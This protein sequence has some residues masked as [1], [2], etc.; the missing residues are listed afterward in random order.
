MR[1]VDCALISQGADFMEG[2]LGR[3]GPPSPLIP[4]PKS[5]KEVQACSVGSPV[6][7]SDPDQ[8]VFGR[9]FRI[10]HKH[11]EVPVV[12]ENTGVQ[13]FIFRLGSGS[14]AIGFNQVGVRIG[15]LR[16]F[17]KPLHVGMSWS[18]IEIEVIFLDV[19]TMV[20]FG[21]CQAEQPFFQDGIFPVP[22]CDS[23][24]QTLL[25]VGE[26]GQA[27]LTPMVGA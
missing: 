10:F 20:A 9:N 18:G 25:V 27:I 15:E 7:H 13:Q 8:N 22:K 23:E 24:A 3:S 26:S 2:G 6:H 12:I 14:L 5:R 21:V 16:V 11:V 19:F 4:K 17:V 1:G